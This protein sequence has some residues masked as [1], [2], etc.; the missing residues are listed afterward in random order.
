MTIVER[1][2]SA[3]RRTEFDDG[4]H[5]RA[6]ACQAARASDVQACDEFGEAPVE[7]RVAMYQAHH[8]GG[9][10]RRAGARA[11][12]SR[13]RRSNWPTA[14]GGE[15]RLVNVQPLLPATFME[16]V[17][18]DFD[19]EQEK[20]AEAALEA[21]VAADRAARERKLSPPC[22]SGGVYHELLR[23][24]TEWRADL[25]VVGSHRPVMSDY[26][27]GSN[28]KTIVRHAQCS[29]LVVRND[30]ADRESVSV[31]RASAR[32]AASTP[33]GVS[34][35]IRSLK[36]VGDHARRLRI[37]PLRS[38]GVGL[39]QTLRG[40]AATTRF[41][42]IFPGSGLRCSTEPPGLMISCGLIEASPTKMT[43]WSRP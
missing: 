22:A 23:E 4:L 31:R 24:A 40:Q 6:S 3:G 35:N 12:G 28:A 5:C 11:Q 37:V 43:R 21:I 38:A 39:I 33:S 7:R 17:P 29:V 30:A 26:L 36:D 20:R 18:A 25:I 27:L 2:A 10:S 15:L 14:S 8:S 13:R 19:E 16:Y 41:S 1:R 32:I 9:R 34:A 42:Q